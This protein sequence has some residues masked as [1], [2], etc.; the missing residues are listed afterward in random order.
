[1]LSL[2]ISQAFQQYNFYIFL[3]CFGT[4]INHLLQPLINKTE[5]EIEQDLNKRK[6][7]ISGG[8]EQNLPGR[9]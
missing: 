6:T 1:M 3:K 9:P 7:K 8:S 2:H 5:K 4:P